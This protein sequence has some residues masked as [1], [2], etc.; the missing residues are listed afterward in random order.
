[1]EKPSIILTREKEDIKKDKN[2]FLKRD[3]NVIELPLIKTREIDFLLKRFDFDALIFSSKKAINYFFNK[4]NIC[5]NAKIEFYCVGEKTNKT[6]AYNT[7]F[8]CSL[9]KDSAYE[10]LKALDKRK[11]YLWPRSLLEKD[12]KAI[13]LAKELKIEEINIYT[14]EFI[15]YENF[16]KKIEKGDFIL[17]MSP[18]SFESAL[19]NLKEKNIL[20]NKKVIAIGETTKNSI[21]KEGFKVFYTPQKPSLEDIADF[22]KSWH[23]NC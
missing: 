1:M 20:F 14:T 18:S 4:I 13:S 6:L 3:I 16:D 12:E 15:Y 7:G 10:L 2:L 23:N 17:F 8:E 5:K 9:V 22:I 21:E 11:R 19:K